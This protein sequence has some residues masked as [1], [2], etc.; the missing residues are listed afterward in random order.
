MALTKDKL[1]KFLSR[2]NVDSE[3]LFAWY[4]FNEW[5]GHILFNEKYENTKSSSVISVG[6][7]SGCVNGL[8]A[9]SYLIGSGS[10]SFPFLTGSGHFDS[11]SIFKLGDKFIT[12]RDGF[13][14]IMNLGNFDNTQNLDK[15][16]TLFTTMKSANDTSGFAVG[17]NG[18]NRAYFH[19]AGIDGKVDRSI[20]AENELNDY[21]V[22][23]MG[24]S[25][26]YSHT[27]VTP[28][29][30]LGVKVGET[31]K[32]T[33]KPSRFDYAYHDVTN[34]NPNAA[35]SWSTVSCDGC[36][37]FNPSD[38]FY[39]GDFYTPSD[40]YTGYKGHV[41]DILIF[42]GVLQSE[43]R[44][45]ISKAFFVENMV[46]A[47]FS[48][49][50]VQE[51]VVT[52]SGVSSI[53]I[54]GTGITGYENVE[55]LSNILTRDGGLI[56]GACTTVKSGIMGPL[57]GE[58]TTFETS[59]GVVNRTVVDFV[60]ERVEYSAAD[61]APYSKNTL[62]FYEPI[63]S[64]DIYELHSYTGR[65]DRINRQTFIDVTPATLN[66]KKSPIEACREYSSGLCTAQSWSGKVCYP[67][68]KYMG[69]AD[70]G[71]CYK[72]TGTVD[73]PCGEDDTCESGLSSIEDCRIFAFNEC[74]K[75]TDSPAGN[76]DLKRSFAPS[77]LTFNPYVE[78]YVD[79]LKYITSG[80]N[81]FINGVLS[82]PGKEAC[83]TQYRFNAYGT[84]SSDLTEICSLHSGKYIVK[85]GH[86]GHYSGLH[87]F[88][89]WYRYDYY[90]QDRK[91]VV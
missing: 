4:G 19:Y 91:S 40:G 56:S 18:L 65:S 63:D 7:N 79:D 80:G 61:Y 30:S 15:G 74:L 83:K 14:I 21:C 12:G 35:V 89:I 17:I 43:Q 32:Q 20:S 88:D 57:S 64:N 62:V 69:E 36:V 55:I 1:D 34:V 54:T 8:S 87:S 49:R 29:Y 84:R 73:G 72:I 59:T 53:Q 51:S 16:K 85:N 47:S 24:C 48:Q 67:C 23:S 5:S 81:L 26:Y 13:T 52:G 22:F 58:V 3:A 66:W 42:S 77:P 33:V 27:E 86:N 82:K 6:A 41:V 76:F 50:D 68:N 45:E 9:P 90:D 25:P 11:N 39:F 70:C 75:R 44:H 78:S 38:S 10:N 60:P 71:D 37:N 2:T 46:P 28:I 31:K